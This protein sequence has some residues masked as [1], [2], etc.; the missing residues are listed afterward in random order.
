MR[1]YEGASPPQALNKPAICPVTAGPILYSPTEGARALRERRHGVGPGLDGRENGI[2]RVRR[3]RDGLP[4]DG[5]R[6]DLAV[7]VVAAERR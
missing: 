5:H 3:D 1:L 7:R 4:A 2:G 6:I